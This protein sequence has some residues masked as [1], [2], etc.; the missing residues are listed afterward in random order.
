VKT[1]RTFLGIIDRHTVAVTLLAL[2][3]THIAIRFDLSANMPAEIIS[4]AVI[5]PIV[6]SINAAYMR[7]EEALRYLASL[8]SHAAGLYYAHRDWVEPEGAAQRNARALKTLTGCFEAIQGYLQASDRGTKALQKVYAGFSSISH[9]LEGLRSEGLSGSEV[10]RGNQYLRAMM[11]DFELLRNIATYR[12]PVPLRAYSHVFLN[13]F[14][15]LFGPYFASLSREYYLFVGYS[16]AALYSLVLVSLD[17][18]QEELEDPFD[19]FGID[20]IRLDE[21]AYLQAI[22]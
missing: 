1:L 10:S 21:A 2:V 15:I 6:F 4:I 16:V 13:T 8:R 11:M 20:D 22:A 12:T 5:F 19:A 9:S 3:S 14:P 18:I 17:N 7:R